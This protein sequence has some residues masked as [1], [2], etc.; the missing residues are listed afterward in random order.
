MLKIQAHEEA[1]IWEKQS[2]NMH[3]EALERHC[4]C[5]VYEHVAVCLDVCRNP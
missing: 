3:V 4:A 5:V 2:T 1:E